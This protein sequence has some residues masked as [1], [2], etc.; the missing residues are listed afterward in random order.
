MTDGLLV[1]PGFDVGAHWHGHAE[2]IFYIVDGELDL[3]AFHP[4]TTALGDWRTWEA[5]DGT[6]VFRGGPAASCTSRRAARMPSTTPE[7]PPPKC[8][9]WS[10]PPATNAI[11]PNSPS[12]SP[13]AKV[14]P[15]MSPNSASNT[16]STSSRRCGTAR[17]A[18]ITMGTEPWLKCNSFKYYRWS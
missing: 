7:T 11:S 3:L 15:T 2:E 12:C 6:K 17:P 9:S 14:P 5:Q 13:P 8:F 18:P 4:A 10:P 16:T 1:P